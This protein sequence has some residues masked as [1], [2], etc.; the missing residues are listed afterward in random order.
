MMTLDSLLMGPIPLLS[1]LPHNSPERE[2]VLALAAFALF[3]LS[4]I[5]PLFG[6]HTTSF[7]LNKE[8]LEVVFFSYTNSTHNYYDSFFLLYLFYKK[9]ILSFSLKPDS[10]VYIN[11]TRSLLS[12]DF[13]VEY[14]VRKSW[15]WRRAWM[16]KKA[17]SIS[18]LHVSCRAVGF[19]F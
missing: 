1:T 9:G 8:A 19:S 16:H 14:E 10:K 12:A 15:K 18:C 6:D 2:W 13:W 4:V 7:M 3:D 17:T 11:M 5:T